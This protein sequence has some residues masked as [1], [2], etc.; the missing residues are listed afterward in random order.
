MLLACLAKLGPGAYVQ[1]PCV[2][3]LRHLHSRERYIV[4]YP[5]VESSLGLVKLQGLLVLRLALTPTL[6]QREREAS[7]SPLP[8]ERPPEGRVRAALG[9]EKQE[10]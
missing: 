9:A 2:K 3:V 8:L 4:L 7:E 5:G 1:P 6:S 10:N